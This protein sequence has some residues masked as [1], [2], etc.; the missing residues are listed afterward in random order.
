M[1][2]FDTERILDAEY[3]ETIASQ[4]KRQIHIKEDRYNRYTRSNKQDVDV[5]LEYYIV[6]IASGYFGGIPPEIIIKQEQNENKKAMISKLFD[7][8]IGQNANAEEYQLLVD[9]IRE[10]NDDNTVFYQLV[11]DYFIT[12]SCYALQFEDEQNE[13]K[14]ARIDPLKTVGLYNYEIPIDDVGAMTITNYGKTET[15]QII[16]KNMVVSYINKNNGGYILDESN[17]Y[18]RSIPWLLSP[19]M[20]VENPDNLCIFSTVENLI[21]SLE[22][23]ISNN[24]K[25]FAQNANA[26]LIAIGYSPKNELIIEDENGE[27]IHN[28]ARIAED[29]AVLNAE[30]LYV[31]GDEQNRGDFKWLLKDLNDTAS[32]NHKKTLIDLIFMIACVPN[33]TDVGFT[34]ADNASALEKKFFPLEQIIIEAEKL[35][36][37]EYI[38]LFENFTHRINQR[39]STN[40]NYREIDIVFKRNLPSNNSEVVDT[41]LKLQG[42]VSDETIISNLPFNLD[43]ETEK[44]RLNNQDEFD[45]NKFNVKVENDVEED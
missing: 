29:N 22:I 27:L 42:I 40:F 45:I 37:K 6:N 4:A 41:W 28:P 16:T 19:V 3:I 25:T 36:K 24:K 12:G 5:A 26:K 43:V 20:C 44:A 15:L 23:I 38:E 8:N 2:Q 7:I 33:I 1:I 21:D 10:V 9:Y 31:S 35:F 14:Y 30:M 34:K 32:E 39:K 13:L 18:E 11:K 17:T